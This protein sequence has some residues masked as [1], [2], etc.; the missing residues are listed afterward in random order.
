MN[1]LNTW[2]EADAGLNPIH[3]SPAVSDLSKY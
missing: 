3:V 2:N 1:P